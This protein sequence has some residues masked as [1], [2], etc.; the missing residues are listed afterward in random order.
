M[1]IQK[2]KRSN[3]CDQMAILLFQFTAIHNIKITPKAY[4]IRQSTVK[5]MPNTK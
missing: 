2:L 5:I 1:I 3:Q 4:T